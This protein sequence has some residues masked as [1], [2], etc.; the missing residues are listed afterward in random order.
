MT[1]VQRYNIESVLFGGQEWFEIY[2][3]HVQRNNKEKLVCT[4]SEAS[5]AE[6][7][8]AALNLWAVANPVFRRA[9]GL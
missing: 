7:V 5:E 3:S 8:C 2:D 9:Y 6:T 4:C 1:E